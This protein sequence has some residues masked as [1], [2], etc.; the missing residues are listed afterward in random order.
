MVADAFKDCTDRGDIVLDTFAGA[1]T[2][3]LAAERGRRAY[4]IELEPNYVDVAIRRWQVFTRRDAVHG[5]TGQTFDEVAGERRS[6][7]VA[8]KSA[9]REARMTNASTISVPPD[10]TSLRGWLRQAA[11]A[12]AVQAGASGNP[13][14]ARADSAILK[15]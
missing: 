11:E 14:G 15:P 12:H 7:T 6:R 13:K 10:K 2:T 8:S 9:P 3:I 4:A 5:A 1:G